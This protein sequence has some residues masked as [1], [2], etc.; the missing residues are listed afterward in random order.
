M[1]L[2]LVS[3]TLAQLPTHVNKSQHVGKVP[4]Y[5]LIRIWFLF[6]GSWLFYAKMLRIVLQVGSSFL[7]D[8]I[9]N[10]SLEPRL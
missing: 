4:T 3:K 7:L 9:L 10:T 5:E 2:D 8:P 1:C 6:M